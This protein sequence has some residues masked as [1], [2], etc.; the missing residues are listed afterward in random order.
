MDYEVEH[1]L[2]DIGH[3]RRREGEGGRAYDGIGHPDCGRMRLSLIHKPHLEQ[4]ALLLFSL[5]LD[6]LDVAPN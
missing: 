4:M 3:I 2:G 6:T 1:T 5:K